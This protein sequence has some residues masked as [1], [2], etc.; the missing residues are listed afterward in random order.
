VGGNV[1]GPSI[2]SLKAFC[3]SADLDILWKKI[4]RG[5]PKGRQAA[6]D[7]APTIE[8]IRR[9]V[10]YPDRRIK[11]IV[12][13]IISSAIRLASWDLLQWKHIEP[14]AKGNGEIIAAKLRVYAGDVEECYAF[15]TAEAYDSLF[16]LTILTL[17]I[18][19]RLPIVYHSSR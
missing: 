10:E 19:Q 14:I 3:D 9:L 1:I 13:T 7:R 16:T 11:P 4:T 8:E 12:Y 15:I 2:K 17:S 6:N 18:S 5:L